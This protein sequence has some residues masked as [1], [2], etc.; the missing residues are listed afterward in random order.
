MEGDTDMFVR[1][2][3]GGFRVS[4]QRLEEIRVKQAKDNVC[5]QVINFTK[6]HWPE[7]AKGD[8]ALKPLWTIRDELTVQHGLPLFQSR[9]VIPTEL[10]EDFLQRLHQGHQGQCLVAGTL[11][12]D[13]SKHFSEK[14]RVLHPEP[15][16]PTKTPDYHWQRVG[17][18]LFKWKGHQYLLVVDHFSRWISCDR[19]REG[20]LRPSGNT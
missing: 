8:P 11:K 4:D 5:N 9:L 16:Q 3:I 14:E 6:S 18:D 19:I 15:L 20:Y 12:T 7:K 13:R 1:F 10:Q 17:M 2:V